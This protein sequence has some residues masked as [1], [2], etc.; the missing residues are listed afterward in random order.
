LARKPDPDARPKLIAAARRA[1]AECGVDNARIEDIARE[2][3]VSK[4]AF[5]LHFSDKSALFEELVSQ[6]FGVMSDLTLQRHEGCQELIAAVGPMTAADWQ[7]H[8]PR[9]GA[10]DR[11]EHEHTVRSLQAM[12]RHRD[13]LRTI[14]DQGGPRGRLVEQFVELARGTVAAQ[15]EAAMAAGALRPD[16]DREL[17]SDL[18]IGMWLQLGRR[19]VRAPARPDFDAWART[20]DSLTAEGLAMRDSAVSSNLIL[21]PAA[22]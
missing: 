20:V 17:V 15:F 22:L 2:A 5:Y 7:T 14:L 13:V 1:F 12:W 6:F 9:R 10:Y 4:G 18:V 19:M 21:T 11:F 8:S 16:L 3:G